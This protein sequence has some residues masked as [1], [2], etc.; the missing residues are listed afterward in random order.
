MCLKDTAPLEKQLSEATRALKL[1]FKKQTMNGGTLFLDAEEPEDEGSAFWIS[2]KYFA[3][4][5]SRD[6]LE[7][8][9]SAALNAKGNQRIDA[10]PEFQ[11]HAAQRDPAALLDIF[12]DSSLWLDMPY[13]LAQL[14]FQEPANPWPDYAVAASFLKNNLIHISV[15]PAANGLE[16]KA[17]TPLSL[18]GMFMAIWKPLD[19]AQLLN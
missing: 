5:T 11:R 18:L 14:G 10:R 8:A 16:I 7:L 12:A 19:E 17:Q 9:T 2:G 6:V 4:G 13:R 1:V 15:K 3:Y